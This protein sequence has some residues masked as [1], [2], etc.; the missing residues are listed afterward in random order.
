MIEDPVLIIRMLA[1]NQFALDVFG[2]EVSFDNFKAKADGPAF[3][4]Y[5]VMIMDTILY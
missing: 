1:T 3:E 2:Y 4:N 5:F